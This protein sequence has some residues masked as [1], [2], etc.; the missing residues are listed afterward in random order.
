MMMSE[1][2]HESAAQDWKH[3]R[4]R[5]RTQPR[6]RRLD[7]YLSQRYG[8]YS[9]TL[10]QKLIREG[11]VTVNGQRAAP[12]YRLCRGDLV[13]LE[14]PV[15]PERVIQPRPMDLDIIHEDR[16]ILV[17][18]KPPKIMCHPGRKYRDD[19]LASALIYHVHGDTEG[20]F[21]P[22]IVHRLDYE[23]TGV[24]V[25]AKT[26][27]AH[28]A[29]SRQFEK[30]RVRKEYLALVIGRLRRGVGRVE[31]PIGYDPHRRGL[32]ST[33]ADARKA[34]PALSVFRVLERFAGHTLVS[35]EPKTGRRHQIRVHLA[36]LG[37]PVVG[38]PYYR[39]GLG[40]DPLEAL[41]PRLALHAWRLVFSHP[42]SGR[43]VEFVAP[44]PPDFQAAVD[45]LRSAGAGGG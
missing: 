30:R 7:N 32:M 29:L 24:M 4:L 11:R 17:I 33:A 12:S 28:V 41:M 45:H 43:E 5:L 8:A 14:V 35:V 26:P 9:R 21:N 39:A 31:L 42:G 15:R 6:V 16:D 34:R 38:E 44:L 13:D 19:T 23:T 37:H 10:L 25:V 20:K 22:G 2:T 3:L 40:P 36:S 1:D 27:E 18:N